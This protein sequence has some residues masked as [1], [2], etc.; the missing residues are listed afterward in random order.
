[1]NL[2]HNTINIILHECNH[3]SLV[4]EG[5]QYFNRMTHDH[6]IKAKDEHYGCIVNLLGHVGHLNEAKDI[7]NEMHVE[8]IASVWG[9]FLGACKIHSNVEL[10]DHTTQHL[11]F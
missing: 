6:H 9:A 10:G 5:L 11:F 7:V 1:M 8:S 2:D 3:A 4:K